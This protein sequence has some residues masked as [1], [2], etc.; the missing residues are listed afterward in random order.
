MVNENTAEIEKAFLERERLDSLINSMADGVLALDENLKVVVYNGA[1]LN[2]LDVN[3]S[4]D[5]KHIDSVL[6]PIDEG[7]HPVIV[8][9]LIKNSPVATERRDYSLVYDDGSHSAI[10]LSIAPVHTGHGGDKPEGYVLLLRDITHEKSLEEERSEFISVVSHELRTPV[11]IAEGS[12]G[13]AMYIVQKGAKPEVLMKALEAAHDQVLFLA[14]MINDL[15]TLSRAERGKLTLEVET[16]NMHKLLDDLVASYKPA[17]DAKHLEIT[18]DVDPHL[19]T[20]QSSELYIREVLQNFVTNAIKYTE[21]GTVAISAKSAE[22]GITVSVHDSGIG[23]SKKDQKKIFEKFFRSEDFRT[24][25]NTGT[26]LGL[27]V[28]QKLIRILK[29]KIQVESELNQGSTF[30]VTFPN[31]EEPTS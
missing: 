27:Y 16:I 11:T 7:K 22:N 28:T 3:G 30:S 19:E 4:V 31:M 26:G 14:T 15:S 10:Y 1:A 29:A 21:E 6:K 23:I 2:I 18:L 9:E 17:A 8:S 24:R 5:G 20:I 12:I 25:K 13:N